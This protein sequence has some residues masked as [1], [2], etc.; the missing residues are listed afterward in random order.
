MVADVV[1]EQGMPDR[2]RR[3]LRSMI[4]LLFRRWREFISLLEGQ[5]RLE[6]DAESEQKRERI[7]E[8]IN[9]I[10]IDV[11]EFSDDSRRRYSMRGY[12]MRDPESVKAFSASSNAHLSLIRAEDDK[13]T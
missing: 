12:S 9:Q 5:Q 6:T 13:D 1:S 4:R 10:L 8:Q 2:D 11:S 3:Q 7:I